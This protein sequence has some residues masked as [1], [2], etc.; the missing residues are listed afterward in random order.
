MPMFIFVE[1]KK[2]AIFKERIEIDVSSL[3][4]KLLRKDIR[5]S[6]V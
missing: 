5:H 3:N 2:K 1:T 6:T 4:A